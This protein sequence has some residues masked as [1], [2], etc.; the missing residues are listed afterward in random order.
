MRKMMIA[1][2]V[3]VA[4]TTAPAVAQNAGGLI[5][6]QVTDVDILKNSLNNNDVDVLNNSNIL[7]GNAIAVPVNVQVPIGIAA[8]VCGTTV[9]VLAQ[10]L[11]N[12]DNKCEAKNASGALG[13]AIAKQMLN[14]RSGK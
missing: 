11:A 6:V 1:A 8:A 4:L 14:Q 7:S 10:D 2:A 9:A 13:Q 3:G 5:T 12:G